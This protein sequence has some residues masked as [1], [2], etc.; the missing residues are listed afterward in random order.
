MMAE[1]VTGSVEPKML[2]VMKMAS[3]VAAMGCRR[4]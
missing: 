2:P 4:R 3:A 1:G